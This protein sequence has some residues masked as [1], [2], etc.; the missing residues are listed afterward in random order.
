MNRKSGETSDPAADWGKHETAGI[1]ARTGKQWKKIKSWF[2]YGL[3]LIADTRYEIL[4]A[5]HLTPA[6]HSEQVELRAMIHEF[7][8]QSPELA[9]RCRDFSA[10][11]GLDSGDTKALLWADYRVRPLDPARVDTLVHTEKGSVHCICPATGEQRDLVFQGFEA[12][13]DTLKYRCPAA[14][15]PPPPVA[16]PPGSAATTAAAPLSGS[17]TALTTASVLKTT[18]SVARPRC[19]CALHLHWHWP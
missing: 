6:S 18:S 14:S 17:T 5:V 7:M 9:G 13:R 2:G 16:A 12:D 10:D 3:H 4:V 19:R 11:R 1:D 8:T 15:S